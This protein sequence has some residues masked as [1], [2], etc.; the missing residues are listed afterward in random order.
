MILISA[1]CTCKLCGGKLLVRS[2][3]PSYVT[4]YTDTMGTVPATQFRKYCQNYRKGCTFTQHYSYHSLTDDGDANIIYDDNWADL[5][6]FVSTSKTAFSTKLLERFDAEMLIGQ[7]SYRQS[8]DIYNYYNKYETTTK[9]CGHPTQN[10]S[11]HTANDMSVVED[12]AQRLLN[13]ACMHV[14]VGACRL[15]IT[16]TVNS[17]LLYGY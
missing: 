9:H 5:P 15:Y 7:V 11:T 10:N 13:L 17:M 6:Y 14:L 4:L 3:R 1:N 2:D 12:D 8:C 16:V